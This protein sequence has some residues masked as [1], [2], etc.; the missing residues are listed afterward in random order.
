[1]LRIRDRSDVNAWRA[2]DAIYRPMLHRFARARGLKEDDAEDVVQHCLTAIYDH[3]DQFTYD[4]RKGR[5]KSWLRTMVNNRVRDLLRSRREYQGGTRDF[6][7]LEQRELTPDDVFEKIWMEEHLAHCLREL[8]SE[9]EET[10]FKAFWHYV[11]EQWPIDK[12]CA[13]LKLKDNNV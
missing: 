11:M 8:R 12:V 2:F 13:E 1:L 10:T 7:R 6:E 5:F 4:P 3:I 9:V